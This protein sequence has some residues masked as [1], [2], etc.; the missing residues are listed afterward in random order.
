M[1]SFLKNLNFGALNPLS[2][3]DGYVA[4]D[5]GSSSIKMVEAA[6]YMNG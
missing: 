6:V 2:S 3:A 5:I 1:L 4:L